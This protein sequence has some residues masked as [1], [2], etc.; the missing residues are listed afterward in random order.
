MLFQVWA[1]RANDIISLGMS[2]K[3]GDARKGHLS[4]IMA[5]NLSLWKQIFAKQHIFNIFVLDD[6]EVYLGIRVSKN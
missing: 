6:M 5:F 1:I 4:W 3:I 2:T